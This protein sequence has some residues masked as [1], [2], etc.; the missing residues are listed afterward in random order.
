MSTAPARFTFD[1]DLGNRQRRGALPDTAVDGMVQQ[2]RDEGVA[3]GLAD[4]ERTATGRLAAAADSLAQSAAA[5]ARAVEDTQKT[6]LA[7]AVGLS[8]AIARKLADSLIASQPIAELEALIAECLTSIESTPHL[9]VRCHPDLAGL[10]REAT[11]ARIAASGFAGRLIVIGDPE[12]GLGD[13]RI[14]W[15]DGGLVRDSRAIAAAVDAA[16]TNYLEARG[17]ARPKET[18]P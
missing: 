17:I 13:G 5:M 7:D 10:I 9:V 11:E 3:Q 1:L 15:A 14:E 4:A 18:T 6:V 16:I 12:I 8:A 2:A